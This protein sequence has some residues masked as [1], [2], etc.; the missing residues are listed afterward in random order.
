MY[1]V[2]VSDACIAFPG[3][4]PVNRRTRA[5]SLTDG[6]MLNGSNAADYRLFNTTCLFGSDGLISTLPVTSD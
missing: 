4:F 6:P 5:Q 3:N 2:R 1:H